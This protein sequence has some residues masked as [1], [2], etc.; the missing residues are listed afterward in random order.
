MLP[1]FVPGITPTLMP[2]E[3]F[4]RVINAT[5]IRVTWAKSH[6]CPCVFAGG[7]INGRLPLPG[8]AD[9]MCKKCFG[10]GTYWD[11]PVGPFFVGLSFGHTAVSPDEPGNTTNEDYGAFISAQPTITIPY[12]DASGNLIQAWSY[13][14]ENDMIVAID[15]QTRFT[16]VLQ[17]AGITAVP[18]QQNLVIAASGAV[19]TYDPVAHT[20]SPVS[21]YTVSGTT[22]ALPAGVYP[23]GTNYMVEFYASPAYVLFRRAGGMAHD[24]QFGGGVVNLPIRF[25]GNT[26][27]WWTRE[28]TGGAVPNSYPRD[29]SGG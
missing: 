12:A 24:R 22:V 4:E 15:S 3:P 16:A 10:V 8:S 13:A 19:T 17:Q 28:R 5:G 18:Y 20:V 21:G 29:T 27:D 26:L 2:R 25:R 11:T 6:T 1:P 9:P 7:S 14:S 23:D